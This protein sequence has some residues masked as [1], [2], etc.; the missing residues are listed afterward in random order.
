MDGRYHLMLSQHLLSSHRAV[1]RYMLYSTAPHFKAAV[2]AELRIEGHRI[3]VEENGRQ[4][5]RLIAAAFDS[6]L[7][8]SPRTSFGRRVS[9]SSTRQE[10]EQNL[11]NSLQ[12]RRP[13]LA[14]CWSGR[15]ESNPRMQLGKL[16]G[17]QTYQMD[18]CKTGRIRHQLCQR[19]RFHLQNRG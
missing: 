7:N 19:V 13:K 12:N 8:S 14:K 18:R 17:S 3:V 9:G 16:D 2:R 4:Y 15:R 11:Q 6:Y 1:P 10:R 5:L